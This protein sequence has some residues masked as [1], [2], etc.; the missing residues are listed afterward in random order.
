MQASRGFASEVHSTSDLA[1]VV[2]VVAGV[3]DAHV[4]AV[5]QHGITTPDGS[6]VLRTQAEQV[7]SLFSRLPLPVCTAGYLLVSLYTALAL[8]GAL[9]QRRHV[10]RREGDIHTAHRPSVEE[11]SEDRPSNFLGMLCFQKYTTKKRLS[12]PVASASSWYL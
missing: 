2:V 8:A 4:N 11:K 7:Q 9:I 10:A 6:A 3:V 5:S 1:V 12:Q